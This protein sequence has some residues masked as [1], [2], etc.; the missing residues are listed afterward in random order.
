MSTSEILLIVNLILTLI[1][2]IL[3]VTRRKPMGEQGEWR[4]EL[5][6]FGA[7]LNK[8]GPMLKDELTRGREEGQRMSRETRDELGN[9]VKVFSES[10][11]QQFRALLTQQGRQNTDLS[12]RLEAL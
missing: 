12:E 6:V 3:V 7:E 1:L 8:I 11:E 2:A 9:S 5:A 4:T 10:L